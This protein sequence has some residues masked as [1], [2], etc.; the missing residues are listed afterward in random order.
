MGEQGQLG[1]AQLGRGGERVFVNAGN[2]NLVLQHRDEFLAANG[3]PLN[4]LRTYNSQGQSG[5]SGNWRLGYSRQIR[6][7]SGAANAAGS[8]VHRIAEDGSDTL[9]AFDAGS[10]RYLSQHSA[11][12]DDSLAFDGQRWTWTAGD[13]GQQESYDAN[14]RL[15]QARDRDGLAIDLGYNGAGQLVSLNSASG[16]TLFIDYDAAGNLSQ[17]RTVY[18]DGPNRRTL[19]R[20]RYGYDSANRLISVSTDLT[21]TD[22]SIADGQAYTTRY[23]YDGASQRLASIQQDDGSRLDFGYVL[24]GSDYR[25]QTVSD[26]RADG[27]TLTTRFDYD[28]VNHLTTITDAA[29]QTTLLSYDAAGQLLSLNAGGLTQSFSYDGHGRVSDVS[30]ARG[31]TT[32]Y[33]YD[34]NGNRV[35]QRDALGHSVSRRYNVQNQLLSE[36]V[37][38]G[39]GME[40]SRY[41]YDAGGRHLRFSLSAEGRVVEHR[42]DAQGRET[43]RLAYQGGVYANAADATGEAELQAWAAQQDPARIERLDTAYDLR[44]LVASTTRYATLDA[45]GNGVADGK[46]TVARY[47]YD[48]AGNL[49]Q[50]LDGVSGAVLSSYLYDG[51]NRVVSTRDARGAVTTTV[52]GDAQ[53]Q[54][55]V[56]LANGLTTITRYDAAGLAL[57]V[58]QQDAGGP[59]GAATTQYNADGQP[60]KLTDANGAV[61]YLLYDGLGRKVGQIDAE[62][63]LTEWL[64]NGNGQMVR[65]QRYANRVDAAKLQGDPAGWQVASLRPAPDDGNDR[66]EYQLY[67]SLGRLAQTIDAEGG[68][69]RNQYDAAGRLTRSVRYATR[70]SA[71][72]LARLPAL[73]SQGELDPNDAANQP[74]A[75]AANDRVSRQLYD[76]DGLLVG[77]VDGEGYLTEMRYDGAGHAVDTIRYATR[78]AAGDT[79]DAIRPQADAQDQRVRRL[80]DGEGRLVGQIDAEGYLDETVYDAGGRVAQTIRYA[81]RANAAGATLAQLR[82]AASG[83]DRGLLYQYDDADQLIRQQ[84]Q[85]DG[86]VTL[87]F[88]DEQG[89]LV[90]SVRDAGN[91]DVRSQ[92]KRYDSQ[93]RLS[94]ELGGEGA[95]ALAALGATPSQ[96]QA[97]AIWRRYGTTY[98]YN[99]GGQRIAAFSPNGEGGSGG[100]TLYY[101]DGEGRLSHTLN[102]LGEIR[103]IRYNAFGEAVETR[104]YA[105]RLN[106]EQLAQ[107]NGGPRGSLGTLASALQRAG[108]DSLSQIGYNRLGQRVSQS[109]AV[110]ANR[111]NWD[112][113][114][115]GEAIGQRQRLDAGHRALQQSRYDRR[116][117]RVGQTADAEGL[118]LQS[119]ARYDAFGRLT[120]S[121]DANGN[122][123]HRDYDK[124]GRQIATQDARHGGQSAVYDAFGRELSHT[125]ALGHTT[126]TVYDDASGTVT[127]TQPGNLQTVSQKN[128]YGET[129][130]LIDALGHATT[131]QYN[132]D[133]QLQSTTTAAGTSSSAYDSAGQLITATDARG[134]KTRYSYDAAG[135]VLSRTVDPDGLK[136]T[137]QTCY[138]AQGRILRQTDPSGRVTETRYDAAGQVKQ[139]VVDPDGLKLTT[140]YDYD[141]QGQQLRVTEAAGTAQAKVTAYEYDGAGRRIR[142]TVDPDGLKLATQYQYNGN[143]NVV[144]KTDAAGNMTRYVYDGGDR[145][146]YTIDPLGQVTRNDYN[147]AGQLTASTRYATAVQLANLGDKRQLSEADLAG[148]LQASAADQ[149]SRTV[150]DAAGRPA[151][152]IDA[153]GYVTERKYDAAGNVTA[154]MRY[155]KAQSGAAGLD[156]AG[157]RKILQTDAADQTTRTVYDAAGRPA[158]SV[159]AASYVTERQYDAAG[160]VTATIRYAKA[161]PGAAGLDDAGL[162]KI[163]QTDATDQATRSIYDA[164]GRATFSVDAA[165]YVTERRYDAAGNVT[166]SIRYA[167]SLASNLVSGAN[168]IDQSWRTD[169][170][171]VNAADAGFASGG[172]AILLVNRDS[173]ASNGFAVKENEE[174]TFALDTIRGGTADGRTPAPVGIGFTYSTDGVNWTQWSR[175]AASDP[176]QA[177]LQHLSGILK[178]PAGVKYARVWLQIDAPRDQ[179]NSWAVRNIEAR[180][181]GDGGNALNM[182][183]AFNPLDQGL[184]EA[185][186]RARLVSGSADQTTHTAYDAAGRPTFSVDAAGYVTE[187]R[188]DV[189]GHVTDSVRYANAVGS[190]LGLG[191]AELR[192]K[193]RPSDKD[194]A[195][196]AAYDAAGRLTFSVD[197][198]GAVTEQR[199]DAAGNVTDT[200]RYARPLQANLVASPNALDASWQAEGRTVNASDAGFGVAGNAIRLTNRDSNASAAFAVKA[201]EQYHFA[202]DAIRDEG[203]E[204]GPVALR[205]GLSYSADGVNWT[206]WVAAAS[207]DPGKAGLQALAGDLTIP[208]GIGYARVW[209][210]ID[211]PYNQTN[212]WYVHNVQAARVGD[213]LSQAGL[214]DAGLRARLLT[215][216]TDQVTHN[217]YDAAG[218]LLAVSHGDGV[219]TA[220]TARYQ[221]DAF[222][223]LVKEWDGNNHLTTR[224]FDALGRVHSETHGEGDATVTD[225]DAFGNAV[226]ITDPRGNAGYFY[227]DALGRRTLQ[228]DPE[229]DAT[230]TDYDAFGNASRITRYATRVDPATLQTGTP[231]AIAADAKRDAVTRIEH[232]ALGRQTQITDAEGGVETMAYDAFGNKVQYT[233][234]L[235][236]G[237]DYSYDAA[238]HVLTETAPPDNAGLRSVKRFEYDA[239]GNRTLQVEAAGL[240]EQRTTRYGYDANNRLVKQSGDAVKIFTLAGGEATVSPT[241]TRRYD[242]AGNLVEFV[243]ANGNVTRSAYDSQNRKV[244]ERNGDGVL[245]Q[246]AYDG[247]GNVVEQRVYATS[248]G[249]PADGSAPQPADGD[250]RVTQYQ[251]D[252]NNRLTQ[253]LIP[254]QT[255]GLRNADTGNYDIRLQ[256]LITRRSYDANGNVAKETDARGNSV[257]RYYDKAGRKL[258]EVDGAGYAVAWDYDG[259]GKPLRETR[260]ANAVGVPS[261]AATLEQVRAQL[262]PSAGDDRISEFDYDRLGRVAEE[263]RL[264]VQVSGDDGVSDSR[265]TVRTQYRYNGLGQVTQK[266]DAKGGATDIQYDRIGHETHRDEAQFVDSQ[267]KTVRPSTD[268]FYTG[269][270]QAARTVKAGVAGDFSRIDYGAGGR[271]LSQVDAEGNATWYDYDAAGNI[272]RTRRDRKEAAG[273]QDLTLYAYNAAKQQIARQDVGSGMWFETRYN[274]YGQ[275]TA[276]RTS[277]NRDGVWQEFS[278]YDGAGRLVKGNAG[279]VTKLYGYDANGNATLTIESG[280]ESGDELRGMS[281]DQAMALVAKRTDSKAP[282]DNLRL[283]VSDYDARNQ[284]IATYQPTMVNARQTSQVQVEP[285][286]STKP[287]TGMGDVVTVGPIA[288]KGGV[289]TNPLQGGSVDWTL[290]FNGS[291]TLTPNV[292]VYWLDYSSVGNRY[293]AFFNGVT[294]NLNLP[295]MRGYDA[296]EYEVEVS[297]SNGNVVRSNSVRYPYDSGG[298]VKVVDVG[299]GSF[300]LKGK[301]PPTD[302]QSTSFSVNIYKYIGTGQRV[303]LFGGGGVLPA[304]SLTYSTTED[305]SGPSASIATSFNNRQI[306]FKNQPQQSTRLLLLTRPAGSNAGWRIQNVP[307]MAQNWFA[308]DWS[309]MARGNYEFRYFALD[310]NGKVWNAQQGNMVLNDGSPSISQSGAAVDKAFMYAD[311]GGWGNGWINVTGQGEAATHASIRFRSVPGGA[312][313]GLSNL[314]PAVSNGPLNGWFQFDPANFG[315]KPGTTYEYDLTSFDA[316]NQQVK[317]VIGSFRPGEPGS[318]AQPV[319]WQD[320]PQVVHIRNQNLA[321]VSGKVRYRVAGSNGGYSEMALARNPDGAFDWHC[322][323]LANSLTSPAAYEFEYQVFDNN[324]LMLNHAAGKITLGGGGATLNPGDLQG[325]ALPLSVT[326]TPPQANAATMSLSYRVKGS[327]GDWQ[328]AMLSNNRQGG[329]QFNAESLPVGDYE[330]HYQLRDANGALLNNADGSAIDVA[331][332]LHRGGPNDPTTAGV[333]NWVV[334]GVSNHDA[335]V[336]RG[337][338]YNAFGEVDSETDGMGDTTLYRYSA[339]GKLLAK[340]DPKVNATGEDG[341]V[342]EVSPL[343]QYRY[344]AMG[345]TVATIDANG[346]A[347]RQRWLAGSQDSQGKV[348]DEWHADDG[349]K[350]MGYDQLGNLRLSSDELSRATAYDYDKLGRLKRIGRAGGGYD[351]YDYDSAGQRI[352]HR[353]TADGKIVFTDS[354]SYD[355]LGR[356]LASVSAAQRATR[357]SYQ[358]DGTFKGAGGTVVGGW[359]TTA[360]DANGRAT[361]DDSNLFGLKLRHVDLGNHTFNYAYN[362]AGQISNQTG[363]TGQNIHYSYY[364]NGY[365]KSLEDS[366]TNSYTLYEYD[367]DGRKTFEGY[368][369]LNQQSQQV[370]QYADIQYDALGRVTQIHDPKFL[371]RYEYDAVGNRR[372]V[373]AEY[374]DGVDGSAQTQDNWYAYDQMNRFTVSMGKLANGQITRGPT[375]GDGVEVLYDQAGQRRQVTNAKDGTVEQYAYTDGGFLTDTTLNGKL[376]ARRINDL[377][378]RVTDYISYKWNGDASQ[379]SQTHNDYDADS[380]LK[381]QLADG[382][383]TDYDLMADG[384]LKGTTQKSGDTTTTT[385]YGY[386]WWDEA[387]QS[388]I[389]AQPYNPNAPGWKQGYSHLTYDV[390]GHLK[391]AIDEQGQRSL[392]YVNNAQGLVLKREEVDHGTTYKKQDYYYLDG[393]QVGAVGNDGPSRVDYARTL[394]QSQLGNRKDQY[395]NGAPVSSADFDQ[396]YE[397]IGPH[398]PAQTPGTVTARDGDTL[399]VMAANLWGDKSLW[400]LLADANGLTGSERLVAGQVLRVPNKVTNVHNNSGTYRV[401]SPG[402]AI[403]DVT[404][405]LPEPPPPPPPPGG[406]GCGGIGAFLVVIVAVVATIFTAGALAPVL[407]PALASSAGIMASGM[408]VL[409]SG[410]L[411]A[412]AAAGA[413][414]A[415]GS[416]VSQG[417]AMAMGMQDKFSWGQ[418]GLSAFTTVAAAGIAGSG[419]ALSGSGMTQTVE[420]AMVVNAAKQGVAMAVGLQKSFSWISVAAS[421]AAAWAASSAGLQAGK[422]ADVFERVGYGT[423]RGM[424]SGTIQS[425]IGEDHRPDWGNLAASSFGS[426]LGGDISGRLQ[427]AEQEKQRGFPSFMPSNPAYDLG[428]CPGAD[429]GVDIASAIGFRRPGND[430]AWEGDVGASVDTEGPTS[431]RI[432]QGDTLSK[433]GRRMGLTAAE[434]A[435]ANPNT[436]QFRLHPGQSLRIPQAGSYSDDD[437]ASAG[438]FL[439]KQNSQRIAIQEAS[440]KQALMEKIQS[441]VPLLSLK[442]SLTG[443]GLADGLLMTFGAAAQMVGS[444]EPAGQSTQSMLNSYRDGYAGRDLGV[445]DANPNTAAAG[446]LTARA[447]QAFQNYALDA[448]GYTDMQTARQRW[449]DRSY[450]S[451]LGY[452]VAATVNA[453]LTVG[454]VVSFGLDAPVTESARAGFTWLRTEG[455]AL[456]A[457]GRAGEGVGPAIDRLYDKYVPFGRSYVVPPEG[458]PNTAGLAGRNVWVDASEIRWSQESVSYAKS[459][460]AHRIQYNLDTAAAQFKADANAIPAI[461]VVRMPDGRLTALDNSRL[462]VRA[463]QGGQIRTNIFA[464]DEVIADPKFA[465]RFVSEGVTPE[466]YGQA[467]INRIAEQRAAFST[468]YPYGSPIA[469]KITGAPIGSYWTKYSQFPWLRQ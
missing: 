251:Y 10:G 315:L 313:S 129:V 135:R 221:L 377:Q 465:S 190:A 11:G 32:H 91:G 132:R 461:D 165:G 288:Q 423:M 258:L 464:H 46:Q 199:Y 116:G 290:P 62:L 133:G 174:Y 137:T 257:H 14:G 379:Q 381:H 100:R 156:D 191:E 16:E 294:V 343:T 296:G 282:M 228:L 387:K 337:Q 177:G 227:F 435:L 400:Y 303:K 38:S 376:A 430:W 192:A 48:Q 56:T 279:G 236:G 349:H 329:F 50:K 22:N 367:K 207:A 166:D 262:K 29:R 108:F 340:Q 90:R 15:L 234:Q 441:G 314:N 388:T 74:A 55:A 371:T 332:Y 366:A 119:S 86:L 287:Q 187:Q 298:G 374:R 208:A 42:Y 318:L 101:Y 215:A 6:G 144:A 322:E 184:S 44:G 442:S 164:A 445:M 260:Y 78:A 281:L 233:N 468:A 350:G 345:N 72:R 250:C 252:Q 365:Q 97:D 437:V 197:A 256:D 249:L 214:D 21:P 124:L 40:T 275:V 213:G 309:G 172:S 336:T 23:R 87:N 34:A 344:D 407:A 35:L 328:T 301:N 36:T 107:L 449:S 420:R 59:L 75:D 203:S 246:W 183:T 243:D 300:M 333:L 104:S 302:I 51:L 306:H 180:R 357:Y 354:T 84:S 37:D 386:E 28:A 142:E 57:S 52:Y 361:V 253:T 462:T 394:A 368:T 353:T 8:T 159:D 424:L 231:P 390:N 7:L 268:T 241:E 80:Y 194:Q 2:G 459:A 151:F 114:A 311:N 460:N 63:G 210:Q 431:Y 254:Q 320:Q 226:K 433:I 209:L 248:V 150:Y 67:D 122:A 149:S 339:A 145:L 201:G 113:N 392:R 47:V 171:T 238:G 469:P 205:I 452:G 102:S 139:V 9:Y 95:Q 352:A 450:G 438:H 49:L 121:V 131:Y 89:H 163:L 403:G 299:T 408:A 276:K 140:A 170:R 77:S 230:G 189:L 45:Q 195:T 277:A 148:R 225:Y 222:G 27:A 118:A 425:V 273:G 81:N 404:P 335:T 25:I 178:I 126:T 457:G 4:L 94:G 88:Y 12:V 3:L 168:A 13:S 286:I 284:H 85:P 266:I 179:T 53:R 316:N 327:N 405:T 378:G 397:P 223:H 146:R 396:N 218:R 261:D 269:L 307:A 242:A 359:R 240:P 380:K 270:G 219:K 416:I 204:R 202:V 20:T 436:N 232:D 71:E 141:S 19:T 351:E 310:G 30:D 338:H 200:L 363:S 239:Y 455:G 395:R 321:A 412:L 212:R 341:K 342:T 448:T 120:D 41:V 360:T 265:G 247:A 161:Q 103:E 429:S 82:P 278:E 264:N 237:Y 325:L 196:H 263:R 293:N 274:A 61:R 123:S 147:A 92:L 393:K 186:L 112:Y 406:G 362:N 451:A 154:T 355:S 105:T 173:L 162:R 347:N 418:V 283:T 305:A 410:S 64:Y 130:K 373:Y 467:V 128:A 295:Y 175:A 181:V 454:T 440:R 458:V 331:G 372:R 259:N 73:S 401:Y 356:V 134:V 79:L 169:G 389:T 324:G 33:E 153:L 364:G 466:T 317:K 39:H 220:T 115:F 1:G 447:G 99:A 422:G 143:G 216:T 176:A 463:D 211:A 68:V 346:H 70:L 271:V 348:S 285:W 117:Q 382:A 415:V 198:V 185:E 26:V 417:V 434:L 43:S 58:S 291:I 152:S 419:G 111:D 229:G 432:Q 245:T 31:Q 217:D 399:Q 224:A 334:L 443:V 280:G 138:D 155:A 96:A 402:E 409:T 188:Y 446:Q 308:L 421:G 65:S 383:S 18:Q 110:N 289:E 60:V 136:L 456:F 160:N 157:L 439:D 83:Q 428:S 158:F 206:Q 444:G 193:L 398:Y 292:S 244:R 66:F 414:G 167:K 358:W 411:G 323:D 182:L 384:T 330:Y 17:L 297:V 375:G 304:G 413:A 272:T 5:D 312:W 54:T 98:Q 127:V 385:Y 109:D 93:G 267:G 453:A 427:V 369:T 391:E 106:P 319:P 370:Y 326:F 125:D 426:A 69:V 235:G 255:I 76:C 24:V